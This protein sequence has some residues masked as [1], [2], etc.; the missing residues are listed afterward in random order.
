V[1]E[2]YAHATPKMRSSAVNKVQDFF[3]PDSGLPRAAW[4]GLGWIP[5]AMPFVTS[6]RR[7][8]RE[9]GVGGT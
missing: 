5:A 4:Q 1:I 3:E 2:T 8:R 6:L 7:Q 9:K